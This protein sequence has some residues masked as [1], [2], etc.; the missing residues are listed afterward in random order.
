VR[1]VGMQDIQ[2]FAIGVRL[3]D[4]EA[5][6]ATGLDEEPEGETKKWRKQALLFK[7]NSFRGSKK[8]VS[9]KHTQDF[10]CT[11]R[12]EGEVP[13]GTSAN[14]RAFNITGL[15][16]LM[17]DEDLAALGEPKVNLAFFLDTQGLVS[18]VK[19]DAVFKETVEYNVSEVVE[20]DEYEDEDEE[21][22][23]ETTPEDGAKQVDDEEGETGDKDTGNVDDGSDE[24]SQI[25]EDKASGDGEG[26]EADVAAKVDA[27]E[28]EAKKEGTN[29]ATGSDEVGE[30][31]N[32]AEE[33]P[34]KRKKKTKTI[35][36]TKTRVK[37]HRKPLAVAEISGV[38]NSPAPSQLE[39]GAEDWPVVGMRSA[40]ANGEAMAGKE[41]AGALK[42]A[43]KLVLQMDKADAHRMKHS[44]ATNNLESYVYEARNFIRDDESGAEKVTTEEEREQLLNKLE[45]AEEWLYEVDLEVAI[46]IVTA[47]HDVLKG[48]TNAIHE[49]V[50]E[51]K[52]RP[53][54]LAALRATL[55]ALDAHVMRWPKHKPQIEE[56]EIARVM[57]KASGVTKWADEMEAA[58]AD[59]GATD[60]PAFKS[61]EVGDKIKSLQKLVK[62][63]LSKPKVRSVYL[64]PPLPPAPLT[65]TTIANET[66]EA[67]TATEAEVPTQAGDQTM[68]NEEDTENEEEV[69]ATGST[70]SG[71]E[72]DEL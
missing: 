21:Q 31:E 18:L 46:D 4:P 47:R 12:Y 33:E 23:N 70:D 55:R 50:T 39:L 20:T 72:K 15:A 43:N 6:D 71:S 67:A 63:L 28:G 42:R 61:N 17:Q 44:Q 26:E 62:K 69:D 41:A 35:T 57:E 32:K 66:S 51:L 49:R 27:A 40:A 5:A 45:E 7:H 64:Q 9:F 37:K 2:P 48:L 58:Q 59:L 16:T 38:P 65:N 24:E 68:E 1:H 60:E 14:I 22:T 52:A 30:D 10:I 29:D 53:A 25:N 3:R 11:L 34:K 54:A 8:L 36:V 19:A 56:D 13:A